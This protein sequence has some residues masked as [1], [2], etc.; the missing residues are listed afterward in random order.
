MA[1]VKTSKA[2][3]FLEELRH[4]P[5]LI[6]TLE[7]DANLLARSL[8]KSPQWSDMRVSGGIQKSQE[9]KNIKAIEGIS[10]YSEQIE[11]LKKKKERMVCIIVQ[12]MS[13]NESHVLLTTYLHCQSYDEAMDY[14]GIGRRNKYYK[15][16]HQGKKKL[17]MILIDT[18]MIQNDTI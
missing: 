1:K 14:L 18:E 4:I 2:D 5:K 10:Y 8:V 7:R 16:L 12:N 17:E 3:D 9:D 6:E 13:V 15:F 11:K